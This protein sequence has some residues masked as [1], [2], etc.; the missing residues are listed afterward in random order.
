M[1]S[2]E[3][4]A[5][6]TEAL[7]VQTAVLDTLARLGTDA[8]LLLNSRRELV[9]ASP[10][11]ADLLARRGPQGQSVQPSL[12]PG[13]ALAAIAD[14]PVAGELVGEVLTG[15]EARRGRLLTITGG[16]YFGRWPLPFQGGRTHRWCS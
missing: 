1:T 13:T 7:G 12:A 3:R 10:N 2:L 11:S 5:R 14:D 9:W 15:G 4:D 16:G 6:Q 8:A